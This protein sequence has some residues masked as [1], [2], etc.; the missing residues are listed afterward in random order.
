[1]YFLLVILFKTR[2]W[3]RLSVGVKIVTDSTAYLDPAIL[4]KYQISEV[5][6][7]V[8]FGAHS[9]L[10]G[11]VKDYHPFYQELRSS[12]IFPTTSQPAA[13]DFLE[14]YR[15]LTEDGSSVISIHISGKLSGTVRSALTAAGMLEGRDMSVVDSMN[16]AAP[17]GYMVEEAGKMALS[18]KSKEEILAKVEYMRQNSHLLIL[19]DTLEYL[20]RG[21]RIGGAAALLGNLLQVKPLLHLEN[22]VIDVLTK[23][24]TRDKAVRQLVEEA[25]KILGHDWEHARI[26]VLHVD[27][28]AG[29]EQI[30]NLLKEKYPFINPDFAQVGP[31][32]GSHTGPGATG[33][34]ISRVDGPF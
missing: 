26:G 32:L 2:T 33:I 24:R 30:R 12:K 25:E 6:L 8:N 11:T 13:G 7:T 14:T 4:E 5:S 21:G 1:M 9:F 19:V 17:L 22:G 10:E 16:T 28:P 23:V 18:G 34:A 29:A 3:R 27:H 20:R 15:R 31:V